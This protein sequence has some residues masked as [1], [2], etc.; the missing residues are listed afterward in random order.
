MEYNWNDNLYNG[1]LDE[2]LTSEDKLR[3]NYTTTSTS[4]NEMKTI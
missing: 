3:Q 1:L 4:R 2:E